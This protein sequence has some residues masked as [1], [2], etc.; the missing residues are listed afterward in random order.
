AG[1]VG[2]AV[3]TV[4]SRP[5]RRHR[6]AAQLKTT[7]GRRVRVRWSSATGEGWAPPGRWERLSSAWQGTFHPGRWRTRRLRGRERRHPGGRGGHHR[8]DTEGLTRAGRRG[9]ERPVT[10][11]A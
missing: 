5:F 10:A 1:S 9:I 4:L 6:R 2:S 7:W 11:V 8:R 3:M